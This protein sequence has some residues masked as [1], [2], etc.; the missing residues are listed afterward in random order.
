M[1]YM[2]FYVKLAKIKPFGAYKTGFKVG[3]WGCN[4]RF[5]QNTQSV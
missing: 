4:T 1:G 2:N 5:L 3:Y